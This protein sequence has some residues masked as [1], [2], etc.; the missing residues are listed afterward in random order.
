MEYPVS[1]CPFVCFSGFFLWNLLVSNGLNDC[2]GK[3]LLLRFS[4]QNDLKWAQNEVFQFM[5]N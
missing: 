4:D 3:N 5:K 2:F 1:I